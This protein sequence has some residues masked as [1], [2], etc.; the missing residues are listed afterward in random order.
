MNIEFETYLRAGNP[1]T[2]T[3][4]LTHLAGSSCE[5]LRALVAENPACPPDLLSALAVD[6]SAHVR[7]SVACN[8]TVP[9]AILESLASDAHPDVRFSIAENP[10]V[11]ILIL[12]QLMHDDNPYVAYR[13]LTTIERLQS[14]WIVHTFGPQPSARR[15]AKRASSLINPN[16]RMTRVYHS[17]AKSL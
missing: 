8:S 14:E 12:T 13:A 9:A 3:V 10:H 11:P 5:K 16:R 7:T 6:S 15:F 2:P 4:T 1:F 17:T